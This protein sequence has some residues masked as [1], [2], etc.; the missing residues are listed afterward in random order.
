MTGFTDD[1]IAAEMA[2]RNDA[3][4]K[5]A[6]NQAKAERDLYLQNC[7]TICIR[8]NNPMQSWEATDR[9]NPLC[10]LCLDA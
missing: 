6:E 4:K 1:E 10:N 7:D 5:N 8:C 9:E 2:R 3:I